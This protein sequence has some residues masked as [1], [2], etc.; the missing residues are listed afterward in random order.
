MRWRSCVS[1]GCAELHSQLG[2]AGQNDLQ[3]LGIVRL[4][5]GKH[6]HGFEHGVVEILRFVHDQDKTFPRKQFF[7]QDL[8][9]FAVHG[10]ETHPL[11]IDGQLLQDVLDKFAAIALRLE[12]KHGARS[13]AQLFH[14]LVQEGGLAHSRL[15]DQRKKS[16]I[17]RNSKGEGGERLAVS[18]AGVQVRRVRRHSKGLFPQTVEI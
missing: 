16:P 17:V 5:I 4:E 6:A 8:V 14:Q 10:D 18:P 1:R 15:G 3:Q 12:Q 9:Q 13:V 11:H 7:K 2:L